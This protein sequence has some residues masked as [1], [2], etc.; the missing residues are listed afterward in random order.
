VHHHWEL[1]FN[2]ESAMLF[3]ALFSVLSRPWPVDGNAASFIKLGFPP[4]SAKEWSFLGGHFPL[5]S[6]ISPHR[7]NKEH[8]LSV[9]YLEQWVFCPSFMLF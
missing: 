2:F 4:C 3:S 6:L 1:H 7:I 8:I 5:I 9:G